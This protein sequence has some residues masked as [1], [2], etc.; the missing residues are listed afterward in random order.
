MYIPV[1]PSFT[2][3]KWGLRGSKLYRHVFVM[4]FAPSTFVPSPTSSCSS[5]L[6]PIVNDVSLLSTYIRS[7]TMLRSHHLCNVMNDV[8]SITLRSIMNDVCS[9][10]LTFG[11]ERRFVTTYIR[12]E[13]RFAPLYIRS[14]NKSGEP[15]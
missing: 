6:R 14:R 15:K 1:N 8:S 12:H 4:C 11:H 13:R 5:P 2:T 9:S 3:L 10:P 7:R